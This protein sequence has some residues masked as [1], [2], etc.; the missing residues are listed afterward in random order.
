MIVSGIAIAKN[1]AEFTAANGQV[2]G[3]IHKI[4]IN[5]NKTN[6]MI[7]I[8]PSDFSNDELYTK[9]EEL[10]AAREKIEPEIENS[11]K[12]FKSII[13]CL[14]DL[15][16][17][18]SYRFYLIKPDEQKLWIRWD[19][20]IKRFFVSLESDPKNRG[21]DLFE[22]NLDT[23][24]FIYKNIIQLLDFIIKNLGAENEY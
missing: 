17:T 21:T 4:R 24:L 11:N 2:K 15:K 18:K 5:A 9:M 3:I 7:T 12:D 22:C 6:K 16:L 13:R 23:R 10:N 20:S 1:I 19:N 8:N 14:T